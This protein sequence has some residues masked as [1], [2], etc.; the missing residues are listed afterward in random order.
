MD[1]SIMNDKAMY[2]TEAHL[3]QWL[4]AG[5]ADI[6]VD[7]IVG[8][9]QQRVIDVFILLKDR[10]PSMAYAALR[11][12]W[13]AALGRAV[14][15]T[16]DEAL[17]RA[18]KQQKAERLPY[19]TWPPIATMQHHMQQALDQAGLAAKLGEVPVGAVLVQGDQVIA[20]AH[21]QPV[22]LMDPTAHA[23]IVAI[24]LASQLLGN[25][26][27]LDTD[28]YITLEPCLMCAGAIIQSRIKRV[29]FGA[30]EPKTGVAGSQMNVFSKKTLN[31][32]TQIQGG[33][34]QAACEAQLR[35]FFRAKRASQGCADGCH[36]L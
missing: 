5:L 32:Q 4:A 33:I 27:L 31:H 35:D 24:R 6:G 34:L 18:F 2:R 3:P 9:D 1:L 15:A 21:N 22:G 10:Q 20:A 17:R 11:T 16:E 28:L 25:Y 36:G 8:Y 30:Y 13:A 23:E 29:I 19:Q 12:L 7:N 26:R 14:T